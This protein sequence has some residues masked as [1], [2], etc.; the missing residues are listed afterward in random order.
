MS[1]ITNDWL[2]KLDTEFHKPYYKELYLFVKNEYSTHTIY[3][4]S[5]DIFNAL[6]LT[7]LH[8]EIGRASCRERV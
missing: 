2:E 3:P 6:H 8:E 5:E 1:A 7:P 4:P